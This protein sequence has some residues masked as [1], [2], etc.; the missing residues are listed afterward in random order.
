MQKNTHSSWD[1][2]EV[3]TEACGQEKKTFFRMSR[4]TSRI[5][6]PMSWDFKVTRSC[7]ACQ[8]LRRDGG[9][10]PS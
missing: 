8:K 9:D 1:E 4:K 3:T 2:C 7:L 10:G 5:G 6:A